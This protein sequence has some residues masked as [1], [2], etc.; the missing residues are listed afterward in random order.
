MN[1]QITLHPSRAQAYRIAEKKHGRPWSELAAEC[2]GKTIGQ[3][4][5]FLGLTPGRAAYLLRAR[6]D[7]PN[8]S[9]ERQPRPSALRAELAELRA[10]NRQLRERLKAAGIQPPRLMR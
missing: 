6:P 9:K 10:E 1:E 4:A 2:Q 3:A 7:A 5:R 8:V